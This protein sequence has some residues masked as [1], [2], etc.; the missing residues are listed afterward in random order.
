[1]KV[2]IVAAHPDDEVI[3]AGGTI[4]RR[5]ADGDAVSLLVMTEIW[6]PRW[7]ESE[8]AVRTA[9]VEAAAKVLGVREVRFGGFPAAKLSTCAGVALVDAIS[10]A[11]EAVGA[12]VVY[13]PPGVDIHRDH[14]EVFSAGLVATRPLPDSTVREVYAYEIGTTAHYGRPDAGLA[15]NVYIDISDHMQTK[16]EAMACYASELRE[17]PHPRSLEGLKIIARERGLAIGV[18]YAEAF[19]LVRLV[20]K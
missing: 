5:V 16:L 1:M 11:I 18:E 8:R 6:E 3:G 20:E 17:L 9:E 12:E 14:V 7:P 19:Q 15:P 2:L 4:A 10:G 13:L